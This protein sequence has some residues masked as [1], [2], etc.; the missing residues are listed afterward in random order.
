MRRDEGWGRFD[1]DF[2]RMLPAT[3]SDDPNSEIWQMRQRTYRAF[4]R[5]VL[6]PM[7]KHAARPLRAIDLGAGNG[8][9][10]YRLTRRG[11]VVAAVDLRTDIL[12]G[13]G[14]H[15]HY[16]AKF[17]P[18]RG[19]FG[20]LPFAGAQFDLAV[21]NASL[22]YA[23]DCETAIGEAI[24]VLSLAG[25]LVILDSPVY[26]SDDDG[27][28][29]VQE[30][31][32]TFLSRFGFVSNSIGSE[33]YLT[34]K[35]LNELAA[36]HGLSWQRIRRYAGL[37]SLVRPVAALLLGRRRPADFPVIVFRRRPES[38][39]RAASMHT[40]HEPTPE[41]SPDEA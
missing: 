8:W 11:H 32:R 26:P 19:D 37:R 41:L 24:R 20:R 14:A 25:R 21:F 16:D 17:L 22:H 23:E 12:D 29:M 5:R 39:P 35:R 2:Y 6:T 15:V 28:R 31:E 9:L 1:A 10:A 3:P 30:R 13:L 7:E 36:A 40:E 33:H 27:R 18:V 38:S 34:R 4:V